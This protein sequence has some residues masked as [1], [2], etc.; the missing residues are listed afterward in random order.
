ML[1]E[2]LKAAKGT[3]QPRWQENIKRIKATVGRKCGNSGDRDKEVKLVHVC[4][5]SPS[6]VFTKVF[7]REWYDVQSKN[8]E[9]QQKESA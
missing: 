2:K 6:P 7:K 1:Q 4:S 3:Q 5:L 9:F 8:M